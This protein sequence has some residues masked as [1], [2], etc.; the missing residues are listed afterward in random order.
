MDVAIPN[1]HNL[2]SSITEKLQKYTDLKKELIGM[3]QQKTAYV[4]PLVLSTRGVAPNKLHD[5]LQLINLRPACTF[6]CTKQ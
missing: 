4:M 2:H 5:S 1:S 3:W 6:P